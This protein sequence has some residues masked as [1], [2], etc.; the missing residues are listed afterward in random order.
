MLVDLGKGIRKLKLLERQFVWERRESR[1]ATPWIWLCH[2]GMIA[3]LPVVVGRVC[4]SECLHK[5]VPSGIEAIGFHKGPESQDRLAALKAPSHSG[6]LQ[7]LANVCF[8]R[9][10]NN[11]GSNNQSPAPQLVVSH[12][13]PV[14][15]EIGQHGL[16]FLPVGIGSGPV[17]QVADGPDNPSKRQQK[18][19]PPQ[20]YPANL[21]LDQSVNGRAL[22]AWHPPCGQLHE[23]R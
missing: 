1:I 3:A 18:E 16:H 20:I 19:H 12:P 11:S 4:G 10:L 2:Q 9:G 13:V 7:P 17:P 14:F 5:P 8:I 6:P 22:A 15:A 21:G 23:A